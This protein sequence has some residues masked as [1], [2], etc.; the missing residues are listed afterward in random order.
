M[1]YEA[2]PPSPAHIDHPH[3]KSDLGFPKKE[4]MGSFFALTDEQATSSRDGHKAVMDK[5]PSYPE[6]QFSGKGVVMLAGGRYSEFA[7]T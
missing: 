7:A 5:L 2:H 4:K 6:G 1:L 3:H